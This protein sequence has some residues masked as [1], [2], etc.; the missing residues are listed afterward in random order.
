[1]L[2]RCN[3]VSIYDSTTV[4]LGILLQERLPERIKKRII[5]SKKETGNKVLFYLQVLAAILWPIA[6]EFSALRM[7]YYYHIFIIIYVPVLVGF[8]FE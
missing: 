4:I 2:R 8:Y 3:D 5:F 7:Y 1:M 6:S